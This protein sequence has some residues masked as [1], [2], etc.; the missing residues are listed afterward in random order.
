MNVT[1]PGRFHLIIHRRFIYATL[2]LMGRRYHWTNRR[3]S[4][5]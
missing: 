5:L 1:I 4:F 3:E 2:W